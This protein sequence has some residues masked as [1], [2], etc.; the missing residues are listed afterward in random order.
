M[1]AKCVS[2]CWINAAKL[3][4]ARNR[5]QTR[6]R[7]TKLVMSTAWANAGVSRLRGSQAERRISSEV[8]M[9]PRLSK[10][11][12]IISSSDFGSAVTLNVNVAFGLRHVSF[13]VVICRCIFFSINIANHWLTRR[14]KC[15]L[16][17]PLY[18]IF[19]TT[20]K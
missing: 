7:R 2:E 15:H 14:H 6:L 1:L 5:I 18:N 16:F 9:R 19:Q 4:K 13:G 11:F 17:K 3:F 8:T 12:R 10:E 20:F